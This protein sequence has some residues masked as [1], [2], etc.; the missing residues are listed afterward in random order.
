MK[1]SFLAKATNSQIIL[2][3]YLIWYAVMSARYFDPSPRL[4]LTSLGLSVIIGFVLYVSTTRVGS[5]QVKLERGQILRLFLVPF[6]VSSF[7]ALIKG[8]GFILVFSPHLCD[9]LAAGGLC[10]LLVA[11]VMLARHLHRLPLKPDHRP[12]QQGLAL[13][14]PQASGSLREDQP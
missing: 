3:C 7:A 13:G 9:D 8:Q 5:R 4:W 6:C 2:G 14:I 11:C 1:N 12:D 10:A